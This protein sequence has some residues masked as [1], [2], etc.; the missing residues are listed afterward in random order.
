MDNDER[1]RTFTIFGFDVYNKMNQEGIT[2]MELF[3]WLIE[4]RA[5]VREQ[6]TKIE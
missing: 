5:K 6:L 2:T 1:N 4:R 3:N